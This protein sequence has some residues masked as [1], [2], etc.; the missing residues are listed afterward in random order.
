MVVGIVFVLMFMNKISIDWASILHKAL[1]LDRGVFGVYCFDGK[2][3]SGKTYS[4]VKYIR[5]HADGR[6]VYSNITFSGIEYQAINTIDELLALR[7]KKNVIIVY[8]EILNMLNDKTIP[9]DIRNDLMEFL[10]QQRKMHNIM[11]TTTQEWL[12]MPIEFRRFVRIQIICATIP[13]GRFGG[14][15][16]EEYRDAYQMKWSG[17]DNEY[18]APRISLKYSKY[19]KRFMEAYDTFERV[20]ALS[21]TRAIA[22]PRRA[23]VERSA[24]TAQA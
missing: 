14:I 8:D 6:Q 11:L 1:P 2:Q 17:L 13:L 9:R 19:E 20:R 10:T 24:G 15:L 16:I 23:R 4:L 7:D 12:N 5:K 18:V 3:G 22:D 21:R